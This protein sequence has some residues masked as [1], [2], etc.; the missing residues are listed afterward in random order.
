MMEGSTL[1]SRDGS[2]DAGK[3]GVFA[4]EADLPTD[5]TTITFQGEEVY[6]SMPQR[7]LFPLQV[8]LVSRSAPARRARTLTR[9][10]HR[11]Q[12]PRNHHAGRYRHNGFIRRHDRQRVDHS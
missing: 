5:G 2:V 1:I 4:F 11:S 6:P 8:S 3:T 10:A 12:R 9:A 7:G